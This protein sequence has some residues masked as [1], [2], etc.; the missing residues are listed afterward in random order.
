MEITGKINKIIKTQGKLYYFLIENEI[1]D[2]ATVYMASFDN[3]RIKNLI[4]KQKLKNNVSL[5][6]RG[7]KPDYKNGHLYLFNCE[8]VRKGDFRTII[9]ENVT[10]DE[11]IDEEQVIDTKEPNR[12]AFSF[13]E[14]G[15]IPD[16]QLK[17]K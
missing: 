5:T 15:D 13:T 3:D 7:T 6:I 14:M 8:I 11:N 10:T 9:E 1:W 16:T 4:K 12:P 2:T 17:S